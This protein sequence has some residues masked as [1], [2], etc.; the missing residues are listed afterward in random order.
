MQAE[1]TSATEL[2]DIETEIIYLRE[3]K[4]YLSEALNLK[5]AINQTKLE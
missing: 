2:N 3:R 5:E 4:E 1:L